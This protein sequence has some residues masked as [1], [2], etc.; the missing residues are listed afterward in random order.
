MLALHDLGHH[1]EVINHLGRAL[2]AE[3]P[4]YA[5]DGGFIAAKY[6]PQLDVLRALK[7]AGRRLTAGLHPLTPAIH[8]VAADIR[9]R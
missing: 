9:R 7:D 6:L 2:A 5:Q 8:P 1:S 3:L 4:L